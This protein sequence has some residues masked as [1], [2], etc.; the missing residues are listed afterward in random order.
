MLEV[1]RGVRLL[2]GL[3]RIRVAAKNARHEARPV[4]PRAGPGDM[5]VRRRPP[6]GDSL[7]F[8]CIGRD[9][10]DGQMRLTPLFRRLDIRFDRARSEA[11]FDRMRETVTRALRGGRGE[12]FF[13]LDAGPLGKYV[14]VHPLGGCPMSDDPAAGVVDDAG[15]VFGYEGLYVLDGSIVPTA[16]GVNPSKTIAALAE[17][18]VERLLAERARGRALRVLTLSRPARP[19]RTTS[20]T[21]ASTRCASTGLVRSPTSRRSSASRATPASTCAPSARGTR[22]RTSR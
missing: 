19:G 1:L 17:R 10:A 22:G 18:G 4:G 12:A 9:A 7:I 21:S 14:T 11:L 8:L 16:I 5:R 13:A 2:T 15:K 6:I 3:G 20:A